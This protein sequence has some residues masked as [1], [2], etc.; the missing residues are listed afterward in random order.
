MSQP[1]Q[2]SVFS[3]LRLTGL[4]ALLIVLGLLATACGNSPSGTSGDGIQ[5]RIWRYNQPKDVMTREMTSFETKNRSKGV[6]V[7]YTEYTPLKDQYELD[8]LK[9]LSARTGPDIWSL[10][11]D[12]LGDHIPRIKPL[13]DNYFFPKDSKGKRA[14]TGPAPADHLKTLFPT[15]ITE[16]LIGTDG[17]TVYGLPTNVDTLQL[18]VNTDILRQAYNDYKNSLG[19]D[20]KNEEL[21]PIQQ[22]LSKAPLTWVDLVEQGKYVT[23]IE[24]DGITRATVALGTADNIPNAVEILQLLMLQNGSDIVGR[25]RRTAVFDATITS[26]SGT[27]VKPGTD[28][29]TF[30]TSF[31]DPDSSAYTW[32]ASMPEAAEAFCNGN[33]AMMFGFQDMDTVLKT[34]CPKLRFTVAGVPQVSPVDNPVGLIKFAVEAVTQTANNSAAAFAFMEEYTTSSKA[35]SLASQAKLTSPY[36]LTLEKKKDDPI[37]S[38]ILHGKA[39]YKRARQEFD[40]AFRMM[41]INV[42]QN[43]D[44]ADSTVRGGADQITKLLQDSKD[45]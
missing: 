5:V 3:F 33:L 2:I 36:L 39:V 34:K 12:W 13:P 14:E 25:D 31:A 42:N 9:S 40:A 19:R 6:K 11:N 10:P 28:A 26:P 4:V 27:S 17:K 24:E 41:I 23:K 30:Y 1:T 8:T 7:T 15:G 22:L 21:A 43:G 18:Y 16:Q 35:S 38:Q 32:N 45:L 44:D 29:L 20:A 37:V